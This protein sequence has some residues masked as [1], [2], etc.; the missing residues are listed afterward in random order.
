MIPLALAPA[1]GFLK[2]IP[3]GVWIAVLI[4]A[5]LALGTCA[6]KRSVKRF[7]DERYAAGVKAEGDRIAKKARKLE[8]QAIELAEKLRSK[9]SEENRRIDSDAGALLV[10]GPG[11]AA[12]LNTAAPAASGRQPTAR[13]GDVAVDQV[14]DRTGTE[15]I[16]MPF[17]DT[18]AF[19]KQ[20]DLCL[21]EAKSWREQNRQMTEDW[22]AAQ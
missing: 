3:R 18:I 5:L 13:P 7:G 8:V 19:A 12:C 15:L 17:P 11:K 20:H 22:K 4:A 1:V 16:A 2:R 10:R 14:P 6:H 9:N 21:A